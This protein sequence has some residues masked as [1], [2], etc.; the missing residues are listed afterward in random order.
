[1]EQDLPDEET[2]LLDLNLGDSISQLDRQED[3]TSQNSTKSLSTR[4]KTNSKI[5]LCEDCR[6]SAC[7]VQ[8]LSSKSSHLSKIL[9]TNQRLIFRYPDGTYCYAYKQEKKGEAKDTWLQVKGENTATADQGQL[10][11]F[12]VFQIEDEI[13][14]LVNNLEYLV[15][16]ESAIGNYFSSRNT[17]YVLL[18]TNIL[19]E[20]L[21]TFYAF[22]HKQFVLEELRRVYQIEDLM[23]LDKL[24]NVVTITNATLTGLIVFYGFYAAASHRVLSM[25][26]FT[27]ALILDV[28]F[29]VMVAYVNAL[30]IVLFIFKVF[31]YVFARHVLSQLFTVL[32]IPP[33]HMEQ[34]REEQP[35]QL[36]GRRQLDYIIRYQDQGEMPPYLGDFLV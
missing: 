28:F 35:T 30:N 22:R 13:E 31:T 26:N 32:I 12:Q 5:K 6:N 27:T 19:L 15:E 36:S 8:S 2:G 7:S 29:Q 33:D 34:E 21:V 1:M 24:V 3:E 17:L 16:P 20:V 10:S 9:T 18:V 11:E 25:Q 23:A 4:L 14:F